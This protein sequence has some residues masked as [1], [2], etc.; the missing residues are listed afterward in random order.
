M[1]K[2]LKDTLP[3]LTFSW[4]PPPMTATA[5]LKKVRKQG[6]GLGLLGWTVDPMQNEVVLGKGLCFVGGKGG[7]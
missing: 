7:S 6:V 1:E 3:L 2:E 5:N 4:I